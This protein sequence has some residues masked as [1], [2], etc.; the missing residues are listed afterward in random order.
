MDELSTFYNLTSN[1]STGRLASSLRCSASRTIATKWPARD[2]T[3]AE[4]AVILTRQLHFPVQLL[5]QRRLTVEDKPIRVIDWRPEISTSETQKMKEDS[6]QPFPTTWAITQKRMVASPFHAKS[7]P[8]KTRLGWNPATK[9]ESYTWRMS[10]SAVSN[11]S[12]TSY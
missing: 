7:L 11:C 1:S 3:E 4:K 9:R 10:P 8:I 5:I 12:N 2:K 6:G